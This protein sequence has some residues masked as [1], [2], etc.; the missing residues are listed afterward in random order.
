MQVSV[1]YQQLTEA[2]NNMS[3]MVAG[4]KEALERVESKMDAITETT[5][6][7][8]HQ[9]ENKAGIGQ[10]LS[11]VLGGQQGSVDPSLLLQLLGGLSSSGKGSSGIDSTALVGALSG[12]LTNRNQSNGGTENDVD[13]LSEQIRELRTVLER[14][15]VPVRQRTYTSRSKKRK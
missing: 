15:P 2:I 11:T 10:L 6:I 8:E 9:S 13:R 1:Q 3:Q 7:N 14:W 12:L 5:A 4:I